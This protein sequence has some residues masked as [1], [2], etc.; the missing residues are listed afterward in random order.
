MNPWP[1][2]AAAYGLVGIGI[3]SLVAMSWR[4]MRRVETPVDR[5]RR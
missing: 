4:A 1:F 2:I 5:D 3:G